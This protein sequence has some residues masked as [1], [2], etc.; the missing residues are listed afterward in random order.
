M[1]HYTEVDKERIGR[2]LAKEFQ[3]KRSETN[4]DRWQFA[5]WGDKTDLGVF[6]TFLSISGQIYNRDLHNFVPELK[7]IHERVKKQ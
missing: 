3:L 4:S 7:D 2:A 5:T 6:N 1:K